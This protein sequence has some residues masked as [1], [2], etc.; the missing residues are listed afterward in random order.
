MTDKNFQLTDPLRRPPALLHKSGGSRT[1]P[2]SCIAMQDAHNRLV[3]FV[4]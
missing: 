2:A 3:I 1:A 4:K